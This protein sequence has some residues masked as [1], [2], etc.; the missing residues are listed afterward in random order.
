MTNT[1]Q[2]S[3]YPH[4]FSS[5]DL[6]HTVLKNRVLMGSMH[7][8]LEE[9]KG[10]FE[11][12][13]AYFAERARGGVGLMVTGGVAPNREGW[14]K[15]FAAKLT[16][17][18]E[19]K[20]HRIITEAVHRENGKICLQI[21]HSG[22]YG[23]HPI[24]V[25]PSPIKAPIGWFKPRAMSNRKIEKTIDAFVKCAELSQNAG[26]DGV[27]IMGSEGYL[28][29]QFIV[30]H[31]NKR[32]DQ[33]GGSYENR[34][35]FPLEIV[36]RTRE[37]L[38][39][40]F[41]I[42]YRLSML[43][44][45]E[46]GSTWDEV[47]HLAKGIENA[48]ATIINTGIGWHEARIPTIAT[49]VPRAGFSWVTEKLHGEVSIP[50]I[51]SNRINNPQTAEDV[52]AKGHADMISM[53]RPFLADA[54]FME[55]SE[56]GREDE[57]NT[58]IGC[59]QACLDHAFKN[60]RASCLVNPRACYELELNYLPAKS[61]KQIAIV[62]AGPAGLAC[63]TI[64]AQRGH[65]VTL[66]EASHEIGGQFNMAKKIP[67]K[68][69]FH[70][71]LRYFKR[72]LEIHGVAVKL[73]HRVTSEELLQ[74]K[75]DEVVLATGVYPRSITL[76]GQ[77]HP[78]VLNYVQVLKEQKPVGNKVAIIGAG[79]I[80]FDVAEFL[81]E[82]GETASQNV[83]L[84]L[85]EWGIDPKNE[86]RGGIKGI[87]PNHQTSPRKIVLMQRSQ[88]KLGSNLGK[89]TGWIHRASLKNRGVTFLDNV[90]YEKVTDEGLY[91]KHGT[92]SILI[93]ADTV[94]ICAGQRPCR[95]LYE[96]L[97][98]NEVPLHLIGGADVA[99][100]LDAKR[101]INQGSRLAS[102]L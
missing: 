86:V 64:A 88:G 93:E 3:K 6:G 81:S 42:I 60:K 95:E 28:I 39:K 70:E 50:L 34:I 51:T 98:S 84:F 99:A 29:N 87:E 23:Y 37:A 4:L 49:C 97:K 58:C 74:K 54:E 20:Q 2:H 67:G 41:I 91:I 9:E 22:R 82:E 63:A 36:R 33:W 32:Q 1:G 40:N 24:N 89:T 83:A 57:I 94:V 8:G 69:E 102:V 30:A 35:R 101:A 48:G 90:Q 72:Q 56:T 92:K 62:G 15:P 100:E 78:K 43:D 5:L 59:N 55:K 31:T 14:V 96:N 68:E 27:E 7:T 52:L 71:T 80:G 25:S 75:Y 47:V 38:G 26:Y 61:P 21:L 77:Q 46:D 85:D 76:A 19:A 13:A 16:N 79:G 65:K 44:L 12:L 45:I 10:G 53:A 17:R 73:N 18:K 11:K 66:Y